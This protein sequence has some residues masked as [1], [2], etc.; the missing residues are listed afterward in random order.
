MQ[1]KW[2]CGLGGLA[3]EGFRLLWDSEMNGVRM[4]KLVPPIALQLSAL[5]FKDTVLSPI[6]ASLS[7]CLLLSLS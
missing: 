1:F 3:L 6:Q 2:V 4:L 5:C 7:L